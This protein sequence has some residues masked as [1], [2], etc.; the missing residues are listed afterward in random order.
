MAPALGLGTIDDADEALEAWLHQ[1]VAKPLV[2]LT[3]AQVEQEA[4]NL[5]LMALALVAFGERR[6][7]ALDLH[8]LVPV[9]GGGD[10]AAVRAEADGIDLVAE[11]LAA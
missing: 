9:I 2:R 6:L 5:R 1:L 7:D 11:V 10:R 3:F 4:R 8:R